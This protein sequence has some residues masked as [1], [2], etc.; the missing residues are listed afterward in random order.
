MQ[1]QEIT[2]Y[3]NFLVP[4]IG[5]CVL[6]AIGGA[7]WALKQ[8]RNELKRDFVAKDYCN[9]CVQDIKDG[10]HRDIDKKYDRLEQQIILNR[11]ER[12]R[13]IKAIAETNVRVETKVDMILKGVKSA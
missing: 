10:F 13:E 8:I 7:I 5:V 2:S 12:L 9:K 1:I 3:I 4:I 6:I 11:E